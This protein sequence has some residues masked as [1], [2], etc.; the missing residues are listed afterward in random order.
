MARKYYRQRKLTPSLFP[1]VHIPRDVVAEA[2]SAGFNQL[3]AMDFLF[4]EDYAD[5]TLRERFTV[6]PYISVNNQMIAIIKGKY[7][8]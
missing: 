2:R 1:M 5:L 8:S 6:N 7:E 3:L 4:P